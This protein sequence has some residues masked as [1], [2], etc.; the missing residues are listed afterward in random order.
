M[1]AERHRSIG[2][3]LA[4]LQDDF[5]DVT[6][7]KIRFLETQGLITPE[8]TSSGYRKFYEADLSRLRWILTQQKDNF[9]PL[10]V[11]KNRLDSGDH[12]IVET[13]PRESE[14]ILVLPG[15]ETASTTAPVAA[16]VSAATG[17]AQRAPQSDTSP[18]P[19]AGLVH[20]LDTPEG[21]RSGETSESSGID[22]L[23]SIVGE[24]EPSP[25]EE[26]TSE[27]SSQPK[28]LTPRSADGSTAD[29]QRF[30][31]QGSAL[32]MTLTELGEAAGL[33]TDQVED[34]D[35]FGIITARSQGR[36][37]IY[38]E[39][40]LQVARLAAAFAQHGL[41][42]RHLRMYKVAADREAGVFEQMLLP[43]ARNQAAGR[44][45]AA[46]KLSELARL[47]DGMREAM[48]RQSLS[49]HLI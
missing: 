46:M 20:S 25:A 24:H 35:Q 49:Q 4:L 43:I 26:S 36:D 16:A 30:L 6:I 19:G 14:P 8:R 39:D 3:I 47:G 12:D 10:K 2:E 17:E 29:P 9:L 5:P 42:A 21:A 7:S 11:I 33:S 13:P 40:A 27:L 32:S 23:D 28:A 22:A 48:L 1:D 31:S 38:G 34:L 44:P 41:E 15:F 18:T 45:I 37:K